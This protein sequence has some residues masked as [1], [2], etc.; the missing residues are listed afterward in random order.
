[1]QTHQA[2]RLREKPDTAN[3][4]T[5]MIDVVF[6]LLV[7]FIATASP[8]DLHAKL[9]VSSPRHGGQDIPVLTIDVY[10]DG[11]RMNGMRVNLREMDTKLAKIGSISE[12]TGVVVNCRSDSSHS[13][14]VKV[15]DLCSKAQLK[16]ISL[17]SR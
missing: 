7:F 17:V 1:M 6:L 2:R 8:K 15:L 9:P 14:L 13:R 3:S 16:N 10:A 12:R 11:Y 5:A 4:M